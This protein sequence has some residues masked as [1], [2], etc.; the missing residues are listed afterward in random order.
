MESCTISDLSSRR[1]NSLDDAASLQGEFIV[2][3]NVTKFAIREASKIADIQG[4]DQQQEVT[5]AQQMLTLASSRATS[6]A[7][8]KY[9]GSIY[10][11]LATVL[12]VAVVLVVV[13][14]LVLMIQGK[15]INAAFY[16]LGSGAIGG[17]AGVFTSQAA[18]GNSANSTK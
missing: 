10:F 17:L 15:D 5:I 9:D 6:N 12:G 11:V 16:T 4:I 7:N 1:G 14:S 18:G 13:F 3:F 8:P 2:P